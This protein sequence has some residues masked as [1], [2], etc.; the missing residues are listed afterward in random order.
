MWDSDQNM[1]MVRLDVHDNT[2][3]AD[4]VEN[5]LDD[6]FA[7]L[8]DVI[9]QHFSVVFAVPAHMVVYQAHRFF[10]IVI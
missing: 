3:A 6:L 10:L 5:V 8:R 1:N 9:H 4:V 7:S 2:F